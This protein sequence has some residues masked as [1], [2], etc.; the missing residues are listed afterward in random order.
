MSDSARC[1]ITANGLDPFATLSEF[2]IPPSGVER[3]FGSR[4]VVPRPQPLATMK[5]ADCHGLHPSAS[6]IDQN[7]S[8]VHRFLGTDHLCR[9]HVIHD[10]LYPGFSFARTGSKVMTAWRQAIELSIG[11]E[12]VARLVTITRSRTEPASRVERAWMLLAYP[13]SPSFRLPDVRDDF[14]VAALESGIDADSG[15][16]FSVSEQAN[17]PESDQ[18]RNVRSSSKHSC[19]RAFNS[20][21]DRSA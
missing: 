20:G 6:A 18:D 19:G 4:S 2:I 21:L 1:Q 7:S 15:A 10:G 8:L 11:D 16:L 3:S 9:I 17:G 5:A 13:E 12:D 14:L